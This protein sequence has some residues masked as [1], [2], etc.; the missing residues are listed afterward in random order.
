MSYV[1]SLL[2]GVA[3]VLLICLS[4]PY[5]S[6]IVARPRAADGA[7][8]IASTLPLALLSSASPVPRATRPSRPHFAHKDLLPPASLAWVPP[9]HVH[10]GPGGGGS[11]A[12]RRG[13]ARLGGRA[14]VSVTLPRADAQHNATYGNAVTCGAG[15][16]VHAFRAVASEHI[17]G[18][19]RGVELARGGEGSDDAVAADADADVTGYSYDDAELQGGEAF[20]VIDTSQ[21]EALAHW[22]AE[23]AVFLLY[24]RELAA[25]HPG[26]LRLVLRS[27]RHYKEEV[28]RLAGLEP[29]DVMYGGLPPT[30]AL[31]SSVVY[32]P[33]LFALNDP[34]PDIET[35]AALWSGLIDGLR[36]T[37]GEAAAPPWLPTGGVLVLPRGTVENFVANDHKVPT[38]DWIAS[39][40]AAG[41]AGARST[42][43][44]ADRVADMRDQINAVARARAV[45]T[46]YGSGFF[47]NG[48]LARNAT[49]FTVD[50]EGQHARFPGMRMLLDYMQQFNT[51]S[52]RASVNVAEGASALIADARAAAG[53][54]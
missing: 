24:W 46:F 3:L 54:F 37:A 47:F 51:V 41:R 29:K 34:S 40:V 52:I 15:L 11:R 26:R 8:L 21:N 48:A 9:P 42:V 17:G 6:E 12:A 50:N 4:S 39:E 19:S 30:A 22:L 13:A 35:W 2:C 31:P 32:F 45:I 10:C 18:L 7:H 14:S 20:F 5:M 43:L 16:R 38:L 49:I 33:P 44:I 27:R 1:R 28:V 23:S 25:L 53:D 36:A